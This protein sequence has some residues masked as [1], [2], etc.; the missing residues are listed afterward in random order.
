MAGYKQVTPSIETVMAGWT[1][2]TSLVEE[3]GHLYSTFCD[4]RLEDVI[5]LVWFSKIVCLWLLPC[6]LVYHSDG[7]AL[8]TDYVA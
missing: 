5:N 7:H 2:P 8:F 1:L 3:G 4:N 6:Q